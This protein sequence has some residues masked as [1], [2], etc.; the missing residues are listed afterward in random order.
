M[1]SKLAVAAL[2]CALTLS[3]AGPASAQPAPAGQPAPQAPE[4]APPPDSALTGRFNGF[5]TTVIAGRVPGSGISPQMRQGFTQQL[6]AQI[7]AAFAGL[8]KFRELQFVRSDT[9]AQYQR[10]HYL[11]VFEKGSQGVMFVMDSNNT[12]V[13]FFED[14]SVPNPQ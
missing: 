8:G 4:S 9:M 1:L 5:F 7:D 12:I 3:A 11:A 10:Y 2:F 14:Q 6:L 13:G